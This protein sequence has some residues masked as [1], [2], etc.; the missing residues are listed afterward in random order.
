[1]SAWGDFLS[2]PVLKGTE[3]SAGKKCWLKG[4][5]CNFIKKKTLAQVLSSEFREISKN[6]FSEHV[7]A[8][9]SESNQFDLQKQ[10]PEVFRDKRCS[11]KFYKINWKTLVPESPL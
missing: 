11:Y 7:W 9:A 10:P 1:M 3:K 4:G 5:A 8:T 2:F 6:T